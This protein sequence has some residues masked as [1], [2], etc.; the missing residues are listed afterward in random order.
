MGELAGFALSFLERKM[1]HKQADYEIGLFENIKEQT[2]K[3]LRHQGSDASI[4]KEY[5]KEFGIPADK[6][7]EQFNGEN[8]RDY[9]TAELVMMAYN[10][11]FF[12]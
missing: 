2:D 10:P 3:I 8:S 7:L 11:G 6:I 9:N 4:A 12:G 5:E 1:D